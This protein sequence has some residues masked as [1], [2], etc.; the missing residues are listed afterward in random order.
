ME[1]AALKP[2]VVL[3]SWIGLV[4]LVGAV[5]RPDSPP[6][7]GQ[8]GGTPPSLSAFLMRGDGGEVLGLYGI[9]R[10]RV[11]K[12]VVPELRDA[13][14]SCRE[15][16]WGFRDC[17]G[18]FP[19]APSSVSFSEEN[20]KLETLTVGV[21]AW[22]IEDWE[23]ACRFYAS[24]LT[25]LTQGFGAPFSAVTSVCGGRWSAPEHL[26]IGRNCAAWRLGSRGT[27]ILM[28]SAGR[29]HGPQ[30]IR[31]YL[32]IDERVSECPTF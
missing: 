20:A 19:D 24:E 31:L 21:A 18:P 16:R 8:D 6:S 9:T 15:D 2:Y 27:L 7:A 28:A 10:R 12:Q 11:A 3:S 26:P 1:E 14:W 22:K 32:T 13:G 30:P 29:H 25:I 5:P 17:S 4:A 23:G